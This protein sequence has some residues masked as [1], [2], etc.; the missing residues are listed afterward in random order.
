M[1]INPIAHKRIAAII[2]DSVNNARV[3]CSERDV[4]LSSSS[5]SSSP[6]GHCTFHVCH[7]STISAQVYILPESTEDLKKSTVESCTPSARFAWNT[8]IANAV[9]VVAA[10]TAA[11]SASASIGHIQP[12]HIAMYA[13]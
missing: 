6:L 2:V 11:V 13:L 3:R 1:L 8:E 10:G 12:R 5:S 7:Y 9:C 4:I